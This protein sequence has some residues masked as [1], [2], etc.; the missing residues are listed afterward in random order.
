MALVKDNLMPQRTINLFVPGR[1]CLF[2]EHSDWAGLHRII[3][4]GIVPGAAIVTGIEQGIYAEAEKCEHFVLRNEAVELNG[5]WV[6]FDCSMQNKELRSIAE[7]DSYFSYASGVASYIKDHYSVEGVKITIKKMTLPMKKGL[8]SSAAICVLVAR[9]FNRLYSLNLNTRGEMD[10]AFK[11][12][13][14]TRSRCGRLDQACAFGT[15]PVCM[16]FDGDDINIE[17]L[18]VK[19]NFHWVFA[20]LNAKKNTIKIL[21]DLNKCYPFAET[22]KEKNVHAALGE[23]NQNIIKRAAEYLKNGEAAKIGELMIEAQN[24]F[25]SM[26]SPACPSELTAPI[27]HSFLSDEKIKS[28]TYGGKGVG[29]Q[30]DGAIQFLAKDTLSQEA[31]CKYLGERGLLPYKLTIKTHYQIRKAI[32]PVAG[33]GTRLYPVTRRIKKEMLPLIDKDGLVKPAVLILMEQ[34]I[35][36]GIEEICLVVGGENDIRM[37]NDFFINQLTE[38][39][40]S[41]LPKEMRKYENNIRTIGE[42]ISYKIQNT[43]LGFGHAVSLCSDFCA[44]E[45]F[46]LLLGDTVYMST[47]KE[48]CMQQIIEIYENLKKPLIAIHRVPI[49]QTCHYGILSGVWQDDSHQQL[50]ITDFIEKPVQSYTEQNLFMSG[51]KGKEYYAVFGQYILPYEIFEVLNGIISNE[52][53]QSSEINMTDVIRSFVGKGLT[54]VVLDGAMY[55]I[56]NPNA[57][58]ETF[59]SY[60]ESGK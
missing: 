52:Q 13:Q 41:K 16:H 57:Y 7:S 5:M 59:A 2:G 47:K 31:L 34:L 4:A 45:P 39:H 38:E 17:R 10:I 3:N 19:G 8:S 26:V 25:D 55:D 24:M 21:G 28:L 12:E 36:A 56:G 37:Y 43:R 42:R 50:E 49:E 53:D 23:L 46:L 20:D 48:N 58:K 44:G 33:F 32:I 1:L 18:S 30:G 51:D 6:D 15:V 9:A 35:E 27:L 11:G 40:L 22:D 54:G 14:R 29:S 60:A